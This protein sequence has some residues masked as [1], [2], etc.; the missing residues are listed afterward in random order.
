VDKA[1]GHGV[2]IFACIELRG[3]L[4]QRVGELQ[5]VLGGAFAHGDGGLLSCAPTVLVIFLP[6]P[7]RVARILMDESRVR[8]WRQEAHRVGGMDGEILRSMM[9]LGERALALR[10]VFGARERHAAAVA[11][12]A[13]AAV[14]ARQEGS[15][16]L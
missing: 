9:I 16:S 13:V 5:R 6:I 1:L 11:V 15:T 3:G 7:E 2:T 4:G 14:D 12:A 8:R 10:R